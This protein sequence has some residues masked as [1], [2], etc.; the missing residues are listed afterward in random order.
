MLSKIYICSVMHQRNFFRIILIIL[1]L[2]FSSCSRNPVTGKWEFIIISETREKEIGQEHDRLMVNMF[3]LYESAE[4]QEFLNLKAAEMGKISHRPHLD[5]QIRILDS[6]IINAFAVPGGYIYFT[7]GLLAHLNS[8]AELIGVLGH[9]MGHIT[10]RHSVARQSKSQ[11]ARLL[12]L[13]GSLV[14]EEFAQFANLASMGL[15][16][17]FLQ[18]SRSDEREADRLGV[19]YSARIGYDASK[20]ADFF[21]LLVQMQL[22][23]Q[24]A[25]IPTFLSTHPDPGNRYESVNMQAAEWKQTL[26][27]D[28]WK[29]N[30]ENY[31]RMI[32]G[33]V[34]GDN[35]QQGYV[36]NQVFYHP[37]GR[38]SFAL[39]RNWQMEPTP[40]QWRFVSTSG[41]KVM[42]F[43][44]LQGTSLQNAAV[45]D[46]YQM[47]LNVVEMESTTVSGMPALRYL[48]EPASGEQGAGD[49]LVVRS[50]VID[51]GD[52]FYVF[53]GISLQSLFNEAEPIFEYTINSF[54][55]LT[56][57]AIINVRPQRIRI[58]RVLQTTSMHQALQRLG[59]AEDQVR[60][61]ALINNILPEETIEAGSLIKVIVK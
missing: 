27:S 50:V 52:N 37:A 55:H 45:S 38:F 53:H 19:E 42:L 11:L 6:P 17:V 12:L 8:E 44:A 22:E 43:R 15:E 5:Y 26:G 58:R 18:Y 21:Q 41:Q 2:G 30:R 56:D 47:G 51:F 14:S 13:G 40:G 48:S 28:T 39:P 61:N 16:L 10:A 35:P 23:S 34:F 49:P 1:L 57:P 9:E 31:L 25:G 46:F 7:R 29:T 24:T 36:A 4:L 54:D 32:D 3:G 59:V 60:Q 33:L 20:F